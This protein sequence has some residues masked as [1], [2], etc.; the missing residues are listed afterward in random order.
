MHWSGY[1][2]KT[3]L[4]R[5]PRYSD[6]KRKFWADDSCVNVD[7]SGVLHLLTKY[8]PKQFLA[9]RPLVGAGLISSTKAFSY[10]TFSIRCKLPKGKYLWPAFWTIGA[11]TWPPEI[12]M[13]E[14]YSDGD[15]SYRKFNL[16]NPLA[17]WHLETNAW[18][19]VSPNSLKNIG[20]KQHRQLKFD[21]SSR[22]EYYTLKWQPK[23]MEISIGKNVV[24]K[25]TE[26]SILT[27]YKEQGMIVILNNA[28]TNDAKNLETHVQSDFEIKYFDYKP[29]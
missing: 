9:G 20:A 3:T 13:F 1:D 28:V 25:I 22:F 6:P 24:R 17:K 7:S 14:G 5:E 2:W 18:Y 12:D 27:K 11:G 15:G 26:K 16:W 21:P 10:G 4:P 8:N 29:L 19:G 23:K